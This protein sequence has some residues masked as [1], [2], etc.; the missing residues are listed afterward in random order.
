MKLVPQLMF[1]GGMD[2]ALALWRRAFPEMTFRPGIPAE[3]EIAG[4][5]LR[6]FESPP[7]HDFGFTPS[8]SLVVSCESS[9]EVRRLA[10]ILGEGG[11]ILMPLGA[12]DFAE[13]YI[14]LNDRFGVSWQIMT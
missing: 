14:W 2:E 11:Q 7:V 13:C 4:Q 10:D 6:L 12:Y 5:S 8:I 1:Q 3:V 9:D